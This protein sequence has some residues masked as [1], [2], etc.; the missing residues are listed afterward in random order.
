MV[1]EIAKPRFKTAAD[2]HQQEQRYQVCP[3]AGMAE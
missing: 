3:V 2:D 1:T